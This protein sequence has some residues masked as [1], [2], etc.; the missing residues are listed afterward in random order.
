MAKFKYH[1]SKKRK[2]ALAVLCA[3]TM[4]CTAFA[5]A[6]DNTTD[7]GDDNSTTTPT[8]PTDSQ[9]LLNGN[10][11]Y[12]DIPTYDAEKEN[13]PIHLIRNVKSWTSGG[14]SS[15]AKSG[16]ISVAD[17]NWDKQTAADLKDTLDYNNDLS[18][19]AEDYQSKHVDYNGM[20]SGDILYRDT[21]AATIASDKVATKDSEDKWTYDSILEKNDLSYAEF[22]GIKEQDGKYYYSYT[23]KNEKKEVEVYFN[24]DDHDYYFDEAFTKPVRQAT[25]D[26]P[27]THYGYHSEKDGKH[28]LGDTQVYLKSED[29]EIYDE[30][31]YLDEECTD[32]ASSV[33]M[34]HN[35]S[36]DSY[37]NG[38]AQY[39]T[40]TS[41]TVQANTAAT[42]EVWVKTAD[43]KFDKGYSL[44]DEQD[45]GA[46]IQV[47]QS[48]GGTTI[49]NFA[50]RAINTEKIIADNPD[51]GANYGWLKYQIFVNGCD[52]A[53]STVTLRLGLG[54]DNGETC[55]G[56]AFFDDAK[57]TLYRNLEGTNFDA[58][59]NEIKDN[60]T[61]CTLSSEGDEKIFYADKEFR[62][63][64]TA[65]DRH[66][67]HFNYFIDLASETK[68]GSSAAYEQLPFTS[69]NTKAGLTFQEDNNKKYA[70]STKFAG[71]AEGLTV[72]KD[73][74]YN[75][76]K[77][78]ETKG[79]RNTSYDYIG[80][81]GTDK[82]FTADDFGGNAMKY[83]ADYASELNKAL[84]GEDGT[85]ANLP[86][87]T[88]T[89]NILLIES[90]YGAAYTATVKDAKFTV[91]KGESYVVSFWVKT[92]DMKGNTAATVKLY[93]VE[94]EDNAQTIKV[95]STGLTIDFNSGAKDAK[96]EKDI[97]N[98]WVQCF[99][100]VKNDSEKD[101]PKTFQI[102]F[103]FGNT[104]ILGTENYVGGWVAMSNMQTLKID[105]D[106]YDLASSSNYRA[107][108]QFS[109]SKDD[110][111]NKPFDTVLDIEDI[112]AGFARP[113]SYEGYNGANSSISENPE[114]SKDYD[115]K[116]TNKVSG[117][118]NRDEFAKYDSG[119]VKQIS[120][121][122]GVTE[123]ITAG[124]AWDKVF[125]NDCW[126][127][128][129]IVNNLRRYANEAGATETNFR[130]Y[131]LLADEK[132]VENESDYEYSYDNKGN[133][134]Y[135]PKEGTAAEFDKDATYY[136]FKEV[137]NYGYV[138]SSQTISA[139]TY[140]TISVDV[141]VSGD[142]TA[143][144]YLV[145]P[146]TKKVLSYTTPEYRYYYDGEGNVLDEKLSTGWSDKEHA[147]HVLYELQ[148][149]GLYKATEN[150][151]GANKDVY[152]ANLDNLS[153]EYITSK[154]NYYN[155]N[156]ETVYAGN[157]LES[158]AEYYMDA[159]KTV[160]APHY[161]VNTA[162]T[163]IYEFHDGAYYYIVNGERA[164]GLKVE[165]FSTLSKAAATYSEAV[166]QD[167]VI[168]VGNTGGKWVKV[169]FNIHTGNEALEYRL[170]LWSGKR[171]E[172]GVTD[173]KYT[174]GA[175]AFD[176]SSY[177]I[178]SSNFD[179]ILD[180]YQDEIKQEYIKLV[181][182]AIDDIDKADLSATANIQDYEKLFEG[183]IA[184][185]K[186]S[187][188]NV[189]TFNAIKK[190]YGAA[191]YYAYSM[192]DS[193]A[194]EPINLELGED[195]PGYTGYTGFNYTVNDTEFIAYFSAVREGKDDYTGKIYN[196][197]ANYSA[198]AQEIS[199]NEVEAPEEEEPTE[200]EETKSTAGNFWLQLASILLVVAL[201]LVLLALLLKKLLKNVMRS[202]KAKAESKNMYKK[203]NRYIKK[204]HLEAGDSVEEVEADK[205]DEAKADEAE[206]ATEE[207]VE[208]SDITPSEPTESTEPAEAGDGAEDNAADD[209][210]GSANDGADD[211]KGDAE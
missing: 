204:L 195:D 207:K 151:E 138:G 43:L 74:T 178:T 65:D 82:S 20:K 157:K 53:D 108:F 100:F 190:S 171:D 124:A 47:N 146:N 11:E 66:S 86:K 113:S 102:D 6:C 122:F 7:G 184:N 95:D 142:T 162:G 26:N 149:N 127:P 172:S 50:I 61:Y 4:S 49:D 140:K 29:A 34:L 44:M 81:I 72:D 186:L 156:G 27:G 209:A 38:I 194:F 112:S 18:S 181:E 175:V 201:L 93:D 56:Y 126:Q 76:I 32:G 94:D 109:D 23:E 87:A 119:L 9:L 10:F 24:S 25:I 114:Y 173:G 202:R 128:L 88:A 161:L 164:N 208:D 13:K 123:D 78:V 160:P 163:R 33:L 185:G 150:V 84:T 39:Y 63:L 137:C 54:N 187:N 70:S 106:V 62:G 139:N 48:V 176:Y 97:Y 182:S 85:P 68:L 46:Y 64:S 168:E 115:A 90:S 37:Y 179:N 200:E 148:E 167:Y 174:K 143:Y 71:T 104:T 73:T 193:A 159:D 170:E 121:G 169:N 144:I 5:A 67:K 205:P 147:K 166:K 80:I 3:L 189:E 77:A 98:G 22:L 30:E 52:F 152:Y 111:E 136:S 192:Y 28:Y 196:I 116:D 206:P 188:A 19:S 154:N 197:F 89:N 35:Y 103:S 125:G 158:G 117:L 55:T 198:V 210:E 145:D 107:L 58:V 110:K 191:K 15:G 59:E 75:L 69:A 132:H 129:V 83:S 41:V 141:M 92:H 40:S 130:E 165:S 99:F 120:E 8:A 31:Y 180:Q 14:S 60:E 177:S 96:D 12:Y 21:Y 57:V 118:I 199:R 51:L 131:Y 36:T 134:Y 203:R 183:L 133:K 211:K 153:R 45:R 2:A 91:A 42:I 17:T 16:V 105:E 135:R 155:E 101:E 1:Y 79:E